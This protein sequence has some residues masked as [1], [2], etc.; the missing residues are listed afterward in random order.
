MR[1]ERGARVHLLFDSFSF[2]ANPRLCH[3][4]NLFE[5]NQKVQQNIAKLSSVNRDILSHRQECFFVIF[6]DGKEEKTKWN[7]SDSLLFSLK[8]TREKWIKKKKKKTRISFGQQNDCVVVLVVWLSQCV[9]SFKNGGR[10]RGGGRRRR[11]WVE[12]VTGYQN[13][14]TLA[15][16]AAVCVCIFTFIS[17]LKKK[18][19]K[20]RG[21]KVFI[22]CGILSRRSL[23]R[24]VGNER[25]STSSSIPFP[26]VVG[27]SATLSIRT[28]RK[29]TTKKEREKADSL[30]CSPKFQR[31]YYSKKCN[32]SPR[33][34]GFGVV[35]HSPPILFFIVCVC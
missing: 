6:L 30:S 29:D 31:Y 24:K 20:Q 10:S 18:K 23:D 13:S 19:R 4:N 9:V 17:Y 35:R 27:L 14:Y 21:K 22:S 2:S 7:F 28:N 5:Q 11:E 8:E 12:H 15:L 25:E 33:T 32:L 3:N 26:L 16:L 34:F 1:L